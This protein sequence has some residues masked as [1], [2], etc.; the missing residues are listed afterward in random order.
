MRAHRY[1][2]IVCSQ[3]SAHLSSGRAYLHYTLDIYAPPEGV[4]MCGERSTSFMSAHCYSNCVLP[5]F[6][7]SFFKWGASTL[8]IICAPPEDKWNVIGSSYDVTHIAS[9]KL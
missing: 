5:R 1:S 8:H 4:E 6:Y 3:D 7:T 2:N 9:V